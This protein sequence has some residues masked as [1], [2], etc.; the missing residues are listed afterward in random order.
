MVAIGRCTSCGSF[1]QELWKEKTNCSKCGG[2][3]EHL[4]VDMGPVTYVPRA[5]NI[6]GLI[7]MVV[8]IGLLLIGT[9]GK[10]GS[11]S[12]NSGTLILIVS[13]VLLFIFSLFVQVM[14]NRKA[15]ERRSS[16]RSHTLKRRPEEQI[17]KREG[18]VGHKVLKR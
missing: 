3:V 11:N 4:E 13:S 5:L 14:I 10:N 9:A 7:L 1:V 6:G 18:P 17:E 16:V 12:T 8:G 2:H 15:I